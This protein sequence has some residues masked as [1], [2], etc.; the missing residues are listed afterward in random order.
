MST[1]HQL[2]QLVRE[3]HAIQHGRDAGPPRR[4]V[5]EVRLPGD[6]GRADYLLL[7]LGLLLVAAGAFLAM[8]G[9][10]PG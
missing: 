9:S 3:D 1:L 2:A 8:L 5:I 4:D 7:V 10:F 6:A